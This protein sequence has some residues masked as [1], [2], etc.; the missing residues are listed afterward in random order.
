M[1]YREV[2]RME[3]QEVIHRWQ[4]GA[5]LVQ[6]ASGIGLSRNT[7]RKCLVAAQGRASSGIDLR[8]TRSG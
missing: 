7:V 5:G 2:P 4:A 1:A 8:P 3:I 6:I